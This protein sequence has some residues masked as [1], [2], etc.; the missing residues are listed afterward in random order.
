MT[1]ALIKNNTVLAVTDAAT[2]PGDTSYDGG[3]LRFACPGASVGWSQLPYAVVSASYTDTPGANQV[4][5]GANLALWTVQAGPPVT[6]S[7]PRNWQTVT[8]PVPTTVAVVSTGTPALSGTY[9]CAPSDQQNLA[10]ESTFI[11]VNGTFTAGASMP[12]LDASGTP[13]VFTSTAQF[14][15]FA[16]AIASYVTQLKLGNSPATPLTIA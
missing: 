2:F 9:G 3:A 10:A 11:L 15:A 6:A 7:G 5:T 16:S 12:W 1:I 4:S 14:Q 8:P 13:H